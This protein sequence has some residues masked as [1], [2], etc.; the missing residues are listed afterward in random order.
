[1]QFKKD[2]CNEQLLGS[3][4]GKRLKKLVIRG[5]QT[6][7]PWMYLFFRNPLRLWKGYLLDRIPVGKDICLDCFD[8]TWSSTI[9]FWYNLIIFLS[10]W[11][12]FCKWRLS[13]ALFSWGLSCSF[14]SRNTAT[15]QTL[16]AYG[17]ERIALGSTTGAHAKNTWQE[18]LKNKWQG[19]P[20]I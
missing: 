7:L 4:L 3:L 12:T 6:L 2:L 16:V 19:S 13:S 15:W 11:N 18:R 20:G 17:G 1:M 10:T 14:I 5:T 9:G 8:S